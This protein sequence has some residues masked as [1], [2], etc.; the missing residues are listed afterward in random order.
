MKTLTDMKG[1][2][3]WAASSLRTAS[4]K[5]VMETFGS[6]SAIL[7]HDVK[8]NHGLSVGAGGC[9]YGLLRFWDSEGMKV[10]GGKEVEKGCMR[11][12][13]PKGVAVARDTLWTI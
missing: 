12:E 8:M 7:K 13:C 6:C 3:Y 1:H 2:D 11:S 4:S 5:L 9:F 10:M